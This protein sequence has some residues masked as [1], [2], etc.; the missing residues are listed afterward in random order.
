MINNTAND[1]N[2]VFIVDV[3][4]LWPTANKFEDIRVVLCIDTSDINDEIE[5]LMNENNAIYKNL[6]L[7]FF[8]KHIKD[9]SIIHLGDLKTTTKQM[10]SVDWLGNELI[11]KYPNTGINVLVLSQTVQTDEFKLIELSKKV[12]SVAN[13]TVNN[14]SYC[15]IDTVLF[16]ETANFQ[17]IL[18][19]IYSNRMIDNK[20]LIEK[21]LV[22][23]FDIQRVEQTRTLGTVT[24]T[25]HDELQFT[26]ISFG[27]YEDP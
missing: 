15:V 9:K 12:K 18:T 6:N 20:L 8:M 25:V 3:E 23:N 4:N 2:I 13:S 22:P 7:Y 10:Y 21:F 14:N 26:S 17:D 1:K 11:K 27:S 5:S 24:E 19:K 16:N